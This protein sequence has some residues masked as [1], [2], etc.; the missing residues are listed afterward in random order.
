M[1][2]V[3]TNTL[4]CAIALGVSATAGA[5]KQDTA[6]KTTKTTKAAAAPRV[7]GFK[8]A[9]EPKLHNG[10]CPVTI[11]FQSWVHVN[12]AATVEYQWERSDGA[13]G[14]KQSIAIGGNKQ[15]V[16]DTWELGGAGDH[17]TV[18]ERVHVLSPN[19]M[20]SGKAMARVNCSK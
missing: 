11:K 20:T 14:P 4:A 7:L 18:W 10:K 8:P 12:H 19:D 3:F 2:K 17:T 1:T 6:T 9:A 13:T 16:Y 15:Y 5:Q